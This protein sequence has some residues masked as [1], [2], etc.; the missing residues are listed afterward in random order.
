MADRSTPGSRRD[1]IDP[2]DLIVS[3]VHVLVDLGGSGIGRAEGELER[4]KLVLV[5]AARAEGA[6]RLAAIKAERGL[7]G[8]DDMIRELHERMV[9]NRRRLAASRALPMETRKA[10]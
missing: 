5:H 10:A 2:I 4:R 7:I 1:V 9:T 6:Q 3:G 8:F